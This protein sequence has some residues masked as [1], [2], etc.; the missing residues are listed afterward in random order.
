MTDE[1]ELAKNLALK[2]LEIAGRS[3]KEIDRF[4]WMVVHEYHHGF[5]P[6]EYDIREID[7]LLYLKVVNFA[8]DNL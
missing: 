3:S 7:E 1:N 5:M 6:S 8:K 2:A 4:C